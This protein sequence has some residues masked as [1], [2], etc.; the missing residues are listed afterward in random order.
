MSNSNYHRLL[1]RQ[2]KKSQLSESDL[3]KMS[4][5]LEMI[6]RSY[7][8]SD[9]DRLQLENI[10][11]LS[12]QEL[13]S[14]NQK[15]KLDVQTKTKEITE[16]KIRL[17]RVVNNVREIIFQADLEGN[18]I[19]LNS[20]W[21]RITGYKVEDTIGKHFTGFFKNL[22]P[23]D[24]NQLKELENI[25]DRSLSIVFRTIEDG[26][27]QWFE[28]TTKPTKNSDNETDGY[29]GIIVDITSLKE[30]E[31]ELIKANQVK[32]Y[33]LSS[34]SH[35]IRTPLNAVV[36][37]SNILLMND[38][39]EDQIEN[40]NSLKFSSKHLLNLI[41]DILDFSKLN[42]GKVS[43]HREKFDLYDTLNSIEKS[44]SFSAMDKGLKLSFEI[45]PK[46]PEFLCGDNLR[47]SQI[48]TNL[49]SNAI[50]FTKEGEVKLEATSLNNDGE[51]VK[52]NFKVIDT[53]I[54]IAKENYEKVFE[55]FSQAEDHTT[56]IYGGTGLGL[57][58]SKKLL[59]LQ[60]SELLLDSELGKGTTFS[61][62]LEFGI[63][64]CDQMERI[65]FN[66]KIEG[67]VKGLNVLIAEDN[68]MNVL[69]LKNYFDK[70][71]ITF[72]V[73]ENGQLLYD[74]VSELDF[75]LILMDLQ[76]PV[77]D[78][79]N[80]ARKIRELGVQ[81]PIIALSASVSHDVTLKVKEVGM[82][83]Y[84]CKP[85]DPEDL[86]QKLSFYTSKAVLV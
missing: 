30:T 56:K 29:I 23:R 49:L 79:Y 20:A 39:K 27:T 62:S 6:D 80:T 9:D 51:F 1:K 77:L 78:G 75:D 72:Q 50:K 14:A 60:G 16:T 17:D 38:P 4:G 69:V 22:D 61:F 3:D 21:E 11:E 33:F 40:L 31:Q 7:K 82:N 55:Q 35:E 76:M 18:F 2:I 26:N 43:I 36:G 53:G 19:Y 59:N 84:L 48:V 54:G 47:F 8:T 45:D 57:S 32:D 63:I 64:D 73:F 52:I 66:N 15:L 68:S 70:W 34:M 37:I 10:L 74:N 24:F 67:D 58:I 86:K 25:G 5:F 85:F 41:N 28:I 42:V 71:G 13:F 44:F 46:I 83:D 12:S 65:Q 81:K